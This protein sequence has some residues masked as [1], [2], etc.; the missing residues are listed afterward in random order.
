MKINIY[1]KSILLTFLTGIV[2]YSLSAQ[3]NIV[4]SIVHQDYQRK[5]TMHLPTGYN[6]SDTMPLV[7]FLHGGSG[8]MQ[9][10]QGFTFFNWVSNANKFLLCYPQ[11]YHEIDSASYIWADGRNTGAGQAGIDDVGFLNKLLDTL[12]SDYNIDTSRIYCCGFSNGGFM[13]QRMAFESNSRYAA[14]A[15]LGAT[16]DSIMYN[17]A[18]PAKPI[19]M[20]YVFGTLDPFVPYNGG[21]VVGNANIPVIGIEEA[22]QFWVGNN[23]CQNA[24][25]TTHFPNTDTTDNSTVTMYHYGD[26][27]CDA[28]VRFYKVIGGGHTWPGVEIP[29]YEIIAGETNEDIFASAELWE[30][31]NQHTLCNIY[32]KIETT[33]CQDFTYYPN[34]VNNELSIRSDKKIISVFISN[35]YGQVIINES[36]NAHS[37]KINFGNFSAGIYILRLLFS[38]DSLKSSKIIKM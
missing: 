9:S 16:M 2:Y 20:M 14:M 5:Y 30:F 38:D 36:V 35:D 21:M 34:P 8:N 25:D 19:P 18:S 27:S 4:D 3:S 23:V 17:T 24:P 29:N 15:T 1:L 12:I 26:C 10:A 11:A 22:V 6:T 33:S 31:F 28:D 37:V 32:T 13:T 7:F